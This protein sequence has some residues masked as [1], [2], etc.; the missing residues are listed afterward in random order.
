MGSFIASSFRRPTFQGHTSLFFLTERQRPNDSYLLSVRVPGPL[1]M[2]ALKKPCRIGRVCA[3]EADEL[4]RDVGG[5]G[6]GGEGGG[7]EEEEGEEDELEEDEAQAGQPHQ[8]R[9]PG[10]NCLI[11]CSALK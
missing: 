4:G 7:V 9:Q 5:V 1:T 8:Q 10:C 6:V 2:L 3:D 11:L